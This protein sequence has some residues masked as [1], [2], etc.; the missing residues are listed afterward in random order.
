MRTVTNN[1]GHISFFEIFSIVKL[2]LIISKSVE[3]K[4][5]STILISFSILFL[6]SCGG[7]N[8]KVQTNEFL[9]EIPS[10]EK[11]YYEKMEQKEKEIKENKD[12][13]NA[14]KLSKEKDLLKDEWD[15][16]IKESIAVKPLNKPLPFDNLDNENFKITEIKADKASRGYL[17]LQFNVNIDQDI[18]N[19]FGNFS[20]D[21][22]VYFKAVD[23]QGKD[24]ADSY[25]VAYVTK[26]EEMK[27]GK[28]V[29][30]TGGWKNSALRNMENFAKIKIITK[31]EYEKN[32]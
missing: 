14:Y 20:K 6:S 3:S 4:L 10:L 24:I 17:N 32:N 22:F 11:S 1:S 13:N 28:T 31:D 15:T 26:R 7:D 23:N 9:G 29:T 27:A 19:E 25:S 30:A 21:I 12:I 18:K 5:F 8:S 16:K 2:K